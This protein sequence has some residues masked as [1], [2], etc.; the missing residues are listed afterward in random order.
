MILT[1]EEIRKEVSVILKEKIKIENFEYY[2]FQNFESPSS[3]ETFCL[4]SVSKSDCKQLI[5]FWVKGFEKIIEFEESYDGEV[6]YLEWYETNILE[7][8]KLKF[9]KEFKSMTSNLNKSV[10]VID[11]P[12]RYYQV[13]YEWNE[14]IFILESKTEFM[15][16]YWDT[17]A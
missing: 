5:K 11:N 14:R 9:L 15:M 6:D 3:E 8:E 17:T 4:I 10:K 2:D 12:I 13:K 1:K 7:I 16:A